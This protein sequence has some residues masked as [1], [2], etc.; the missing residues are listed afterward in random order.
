MDQS[1]NNLL[2]TRKDEILVKWVNL[3][4]DDYQSEGAK[5]FKEQ[6]DPFKNPVG[7]TISRETT[8]LYDQLLG[9]MDVD[10]INRSLDNIIKI[11]AV[12]ELSPT[13]AVSF[14]YL[15]KDVIAEELLDVE[16]IEFQTP[17]LIEIFDK[18][19]QMTKNAFDI[20][21]NNREKIGQIRINEMKKRF[22]F[23]DI[24]KMPKKKN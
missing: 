9:A 24:N 1:L 10:I 11:R 22:A 12:Q 6:K 16:E 19:D 23:I 3:I 5:F 7:G 15:L 13:E 20:Y 17:A 14:I 18:I 2:L 21:M 4:F 8:K